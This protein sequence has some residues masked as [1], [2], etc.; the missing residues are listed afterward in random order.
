MRVDFLC[1]NDHD[2]RISNGRLKFTIEEISGI[3]EG[4]TNSILD[5]CATM[6]LDGDSDGNVKVSK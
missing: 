3:F 6:L 5:S 2:L 1:D 4:V